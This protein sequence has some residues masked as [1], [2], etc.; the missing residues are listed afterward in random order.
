MSDE[1]LER[2]ILAIERKLGL[3][4]PLLPEDLDRLWAKK[5]KEKVEDFLRNVDLAKDSPL[6]IRLRDFDLAWREAE[7]LLKIMDQ[8]QKDLIRYWGDDWFW[9][10]R[11]KLWHVREKFFSRIA[12]AFEAR[13]HAL[14]SRFK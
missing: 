13:A 9:Q 4:K 5:I 2:R 12:P 3:R 10:V 11:G 8:N 1:N 6:S 14:L 7:E